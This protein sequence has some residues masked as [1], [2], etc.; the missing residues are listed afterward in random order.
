VSDPYTPAHLAAGAIK[1]AALRLADKYLFHTKVLEKF[2]LAESS[3]VGTMGVSASGEGV[4]LLFDPEFVLSLPIDQLRGVLLHEVHHVVLGHLGLD[5]KDHPDSWAITVA[6]ELSVNEFVREPLPGDCVT[7]DQFPGFPPMESTQQR[8]ERLRRIPQRDRL[9]LQ[10]LVIILRG[11]CPKSPGGKSGKG[12]R[13]SVVVL[14]DHG[15]WQELGPRERQ[16]LADLVGEA[17]EESGGMPKEL[18]DALSRSSVS[19]R[20]VGNVPGDGVQILADATAGKVDWRTVLRRYVGQVLRPRPVYH[21]PPRRFPHLVGILPGRRRGRSQ[22]S[23]VAVLDTSGSVG[24]DE[25]ERINGELL[26]ISKVRPVQVVEADCEVQR[27]GRYKGRLDSVLGRG[28]T[29]FRPALDPEFLR[30]LRAELVVY[31][32]DGL[33]PAPEK[34]PPCPVIWCLVPGGEVPAP[35][36][37]VVRMD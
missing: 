20:S 25:L 28:G 13:G 9:P 35:W 29:D 26:R 1:R 6:M 19:T 31:F 14:D 7:L 18:R 5:W 33:G 23:V 2:R 4:L 10:Q 37:R 8:Y 3:T 17:A 16:A 22:A 12:G 15:V 32:T 21:R 24:P 27:V 30:G 36:G 11:V 34:P